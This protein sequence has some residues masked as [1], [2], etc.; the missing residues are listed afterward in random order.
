MA[1]YRLSALDLSTRIMLAREML[2][3]IPERKWG[4][5]TELACSQ[6]RETDSL[7][8]YNLP[9]WRYHLLC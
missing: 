8:F 9:F 4:R 5:A 6:E 2:Q 1:Y 7:S 3:P